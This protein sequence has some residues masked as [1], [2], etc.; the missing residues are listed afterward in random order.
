MG[1]RKVHADP[2]AGDVLL[3]KTFRVAVTQRDGDV[4]FYSVTD[5]HSAKREARQTLAEWSEW[6]K[7]AKVKQR[8]TSQ[9]ECVIIRFGA[10]GVCRC[11][12][13]EYL[14]SGVHSTDAGFWKPEHCP[15]SV[16]K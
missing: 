10:S 7:G 9:N 8:G 13:G 5:S 4:V 15:M 2:A 16:H 6:T 11:G 12:C 1:A 3:W 14:E